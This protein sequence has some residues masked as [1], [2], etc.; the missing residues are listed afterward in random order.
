M[1]PAEISWPRRAFVGVDGRGLPSMGSPKMGQKRVGPE[2]GSTAHS[3]ESLTS[4]KGHAHGPYF[5]TVLI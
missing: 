4:V 5:Q 1:I 3:P 2:P